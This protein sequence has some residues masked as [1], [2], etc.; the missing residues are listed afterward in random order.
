MKNK[1]ILILILIADILFFS[2]VVFIF[3]QMSVRVGFLSGDPL[4]IAVSCAGMLAALGFLIYLNSVLISRSRRIPVVIPI[5]T[6]KINTLDDCIQAANEY[7]NANGSLF[8]NQLNAILLQITRLKRKKIATEK[9]LADNFDTSEISYAN[10]SSAQDKLE[11]LFVLST[12][13]LLYRLSSFD[14]EEYQAGIG[15]NLMGTATQK[16]REELY[17]E[18]LNLTSEV[19]QNN[20]MILIKFDKLAL[21]LSKINT[22]DSDDIMK[23]LDINE[24]DRIIHDTKYYKMSE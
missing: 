11:E 2:I 9:I 5:N 17:H 24:I 22:L 13:S 3:S 18:H 14:D 10:F 4:T 1:L 20:E 12:K 21:E 15:M 23:L 7:I 8:L 16:A 6:S 19:L